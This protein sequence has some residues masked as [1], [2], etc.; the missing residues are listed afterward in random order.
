M[1]QKKYFPMYG[2]IALALIAGLFFFFW[3]KP[4][5]FIEQTAQSESATPQV[6]DSTAKEASTTNLPTKGAD[7]SDVPKN[8]KTLWKVF[9]QYLVYAKN[10]DKVALATL[11][12]KV[13][14]TC[15]DSKQEKEC[16]EKMDA[17]YAIGSKLK[18]GDFVNVLEDDKQAILSTNYTRVTSETEL[19]AT[20]AVIVFIKDDKG[21]PKLASLK[22]NE[23]WVVNRTSTSTVSA[24]E[25]KLE[26]ML[27]DTDNDGKTDELELC[28]FPNNYVVFSC[29]K[30]DP[31]KK[32]SN[33]NGY[34]DGV[35]SYLS[36]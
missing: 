13:S 36:K 17:V 19:S 31:T 6:P 16:F 4:T 34:W 14:D 15:A 9:E 3:Q 30:T 22:P 32:D 29:E 20:K 35:E 21:N 23:T 10:H 1:Q 25:T 27:V 2:L 5:I 11:S 24:L 8:P 28:I 26:G 18:Q 7:S 33:T 12:Y